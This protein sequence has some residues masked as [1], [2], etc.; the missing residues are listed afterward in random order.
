M[1]K[2]VKEFMEQKCSGPNA[3]GL[4]QALPDLWIRPNAQ[5]LGRGPAPFVTLALDSSF[6]TAE[7]YKTFD[8]KGYVCNFVT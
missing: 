7:E 3:P 8:V 5:P 6:H 2:Y 4:D 1:E